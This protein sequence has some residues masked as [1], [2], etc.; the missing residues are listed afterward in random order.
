MAGMSTSG[1]PWRQMPVLH[2]RLVRLEPL[3]RGHLP[4]ILAAAAALEALPF[5]ALPTPGT[6]QSWLDAA[7]AALDQERALPFAVL[8]R[9]G[10]LVGSSRF[11]DIDRSLPKASI[12]YTWYLP[13]VRGSGVNSECKLLLLQYAF[14]V[15]GCHRIAFETSTLNTVSRRALAA[16]GAREEGILRRHKR[17]PD[18]T[19]RDTV[20]FSIIDSEWPDVR[21]RLLAR[22]AR[23]GGPQA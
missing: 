13:G 14:E 21:E 15:L 16:I 17:H 10:A 20:V 6:A 2:G 5:A 1:D 8:D 19:L 22:L 12:G 9:D 11:Y 18:G 7:L 23:H 3:S 4:D